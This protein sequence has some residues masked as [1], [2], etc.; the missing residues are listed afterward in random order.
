VSGWYGLL[1]S[2]VKMMGVFAA[3]AVAA[4]GFVAFAAWRTSLRDR[5]IGVGSID[6]GAADTIRMGPETLRQ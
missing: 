2:T 6:R 5:L 4:R 3:V 1:I